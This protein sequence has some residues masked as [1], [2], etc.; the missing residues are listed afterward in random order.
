L[1]VD[2]TGSF[3]GEINN[4]Q[5]ALTTTIVPGIRAEIPDSA[6]GVSR[7]EDFPV[8]P[9]GNVD[10]SGGRDDAPFQ[11]HQQVTTDV[12]RVQAGVNA[13]DAPMG[14]GGDEAESDL[15]ALYQIA[16]GAGVAWSVRDSSSGALVT[17]SVPPFAPDPATP[18]GGT[19]G[20][21]GF[22]DGA[23]PIVIHCTD[24]PFHLPL[25]PDPTSGYRAAGITEA[26]TA[27]ETFAAL[28]ALSVRV[29]GISTSSR[30]RP[31]LLA[32]ARRT[33]AYVPP[34]GGACPMGVDGAP[35]D[36]EDVG[37]ELMCPL[38]YDVREDGSG[39]AGTILTGVTTLVGA[40]RFESVGT[41]V[42]DDPHGFFQYAVPQSAT[43][44]PGAAM[45][46]VADTDG[47][48]YFDTFR[49]LTPGT[50]VRFLVILRNDTVPRGTSDQVFTIYIQVIGDG[51][52]VLDEKP[53]VIIVPRAGATDKRDG[54]G[55]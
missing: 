17:G 47:D 46:T 32:T 33:R 34:T 25:D 48:G 42:R 39:L 37:G 41:R 55:P 11:L 23:F 40:M 2:T 13:L 28:N 16:T 22:R 50:V 9:F 31:S 29:V 38:V 3:S 30:A 19:L 20:G 12:A 7:F 4:I 45:P 5:S 6:F 27:E 53:V 21:V 24:A 35:R 18:G 51:V 14:C 52:A 36:P 44:P 1:S 54:A 43:P 8:Y 10:C 49:D 15:E 26:H